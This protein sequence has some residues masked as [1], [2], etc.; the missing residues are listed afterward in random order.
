MNGYPYFQFHVDRWLTGKISAFDLDEQGLFLHFCMLAWT[1]HGVFDI[2][3][4][5]VQRRF[6]KKAAWIDATVTAFRQVGI[7]A[8]EGSRWRIKFLDAQIEEMDAIRNKR[9]SAGRTSAGLR[10][11]K[12]GETREE[13]TREEKPVE[14][15]LNTC[16]THVADGFDDAWKAY[17]DKA[18]KQRA[19]E[20]YLKWRKAG[21]T[22]EQIL[23]GIARYLVYVAKRREAGF[24][25]L[26]LRNGQTFF[27]Q[28]GWQDEWSI[29]DT[30]KTPQR[31]A[32]GNPRVERDRAV[33]TV[34]DKLWHID[35]T[36]GGEHDDFRRAMSNCAKEYR[37][38]GKNADGQDVVT[39]AM[40]VIKYR[41]EL[42]GKAVTHGRG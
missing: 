10:K 33:Q 4:T 6:R 34:V 8:P 40:E 41:R 21:D 32:T 13:K 36:L 12:T 37:D 15:M 23:A 24:A 3:S 1:G 26:K 35:E 18:G 5:S 28:R 29:D 39:V 9:A 27:N 42:K 19:H 22:Q 14:H 20:A 16:S 17:P 7:I 38:M 31:P 25:E 30:A 11:E 2:C